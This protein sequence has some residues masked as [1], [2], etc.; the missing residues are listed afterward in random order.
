MLQEIIDVMH[1]C[2]E[3]ILE[4]T[5]IDRKIHR[6]EGKGNF[7]TEYDSRVQAILKEKL[8]ALLPDAVFFGEED[9]AEQADISEGYA[10]IVDPIDGTAN[11]TRGLRMSCISVALA[12]NG[13]PMLGVV[14]NPYA[15]ETF[16]AQRGQGAYL[17]GQRIHVSD[18]PLERGLF[19]LGT[20]PYQAEL[21]RKT[22]E[23]AYRYF[24]I[25][26]DLRRSGSAAL[27]LCTVACGRAE[28]YFE[29]CLCPWDY[30][31]GALIVEEAGGIVSD[32]EGNPITYD[33]KQTV[34]ARGSAVELI[35]E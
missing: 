21:S 30:A 24:T 16:V 31:A 17:N 2:G 12:L 11:F 27:D 10:F 20:S 5:D 35:R 7:V 9:G 18:R 14:Y 32:L 15:K 33:R 8:Q 1:K 25:A 29:M 34:A 6:K 26:E 13:Q 23:T 3:I 4:A 28:L 22:F 19:L